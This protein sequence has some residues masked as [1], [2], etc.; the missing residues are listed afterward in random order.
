[1]DLDRDTGRIV[2][3]LVGIAGAVEL[4]A[5]GSRLTENLSNGYGYAGIIVA[6]LALMRP[7]AIIPVA[8]VFGAVQVGGNAIRT[9]DVSSAVSGILQALILMGALVVSVLMAYRVRLVSS[10]VDVDTRPEPVAT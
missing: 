9:L 5:S 6:A 7:W 8:I 1:M 4:S 3:V 10:S 2:V